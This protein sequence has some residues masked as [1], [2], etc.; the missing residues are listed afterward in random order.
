MRL[1]DDA[2][3]ANLLSFITDSVEPGATVHTDG[4]GGNA[5][6]RKSGYQHHVMVVVQRRKNHLSCS[7]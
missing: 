7:P 4:W 3:G 1:I 5:A 2:S 6:V